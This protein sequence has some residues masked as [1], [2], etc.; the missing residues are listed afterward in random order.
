MQGNTAGTKAIVTRRTLLACAA[1]FSIAL[2]QPRISL[3]GEPS[4]KK[5]AANTASKTHYLISA[6]LREGV[7]DFTFRLVHSVQSATGVDEATGMFMRLVLEKYL[8]YA[9]A[10]T[11]VTDIVL[12]PGTCL[13]SQPGSPR[14]SAQTLYAVSAVLG[15]KSNDTDTLLVNGWLPGNSADEALDRVLRDVTAKYRS[16]TPLSTLVNPL[17]MALFGCPAPT[18]VRIH[19][20]RV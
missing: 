7:K 16:H 11:T 6:A 14:K 3:A 2:T 15:K 4:R 17:D 20:K 8:G 9:V 18:P 12:P 19:G 1:G 13:A 5:S 10:Q